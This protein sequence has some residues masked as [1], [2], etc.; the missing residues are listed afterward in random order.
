MLKPEEMARIPATQYAGWCCQ[1]MYHYAGASL[2]GGMETVPILATTLGSN[3]LANMFNNAKINRLEVSF[4]EWTAGTSNWVAGVPG[5]GTFVKPS[6]LSEDYGA[7]N[8]P[9]GWT[10]VNK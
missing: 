6:A 3:S 7:N 10:V 4:T 2:T 5:S 1:Y 9:S 8:I